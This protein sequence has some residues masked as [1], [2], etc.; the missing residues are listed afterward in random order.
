[1]TPEEILSVIAVSLYASPA[2]PTYV[3][4]ARQRLSATF[5]GANYTL[6]VALLSAHMYTLNSRR[7]GESGVVT[8]QA[9]GRLF[10]SYGGVGVIRDDYDL[11]N[12]GIQ[13]KDLTR[14]C[15]VGAT[16]TSLAVYDAELGG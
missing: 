14:N 8:Y 12:Y 10:K 5:F 1:M 16:T 4:L 3:A 11:T 13:L 7:E 6:A 15:G 2:M 9:E